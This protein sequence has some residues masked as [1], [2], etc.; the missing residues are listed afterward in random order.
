MLATSRRIGVAPARSAF[1]SLAARRVLV[2][3][4][5]GFIGQQVVKALLASSVEHVSA[6][7]TRP[8]SDDVF[9]PRFRRVVVR[10]CRDI[11]EPSDDVL[12]GIDVVLHLA[13]HVSVPQSLCDPL[14]DATAN[15]MGTVALLESCRRVGVRRFVYS[16]SA[17][18]YG[19][20]Q[21]LPLDEQHSTRPESP[22][23]LSKLTA[24]RYCL[25]YGQLHGMSVVALRYFNVYGPNQ[26][27]HNGYSAVVP[28]FL[29]RIERELPLVVEGDGSHTRDFV[30]VAD[31]ARANVLA[32]GSDFQG[33]L[34]VGSGRATSILELARSLGGPG[35]PIEHAPGRAGDIPASVAD[36]QAAAAAL[37]YRTTISLESGLAA[38]RGT[39]ESRSRAG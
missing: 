16:S 31:V 36:I 20:P 17:A 27:L 25:L 13:A 22:Y 21:R 11:L 33:V 3:G 2:T 30:H 18:V 28:R 24:E 19:T 8:A 37:G 1:P 7:D 29:E 38:L 39:P 9:G 15:I 23:G 14:G 34:N 26:P 35:Y 10:H 32:A 6:V 5:S 12:A 4:A